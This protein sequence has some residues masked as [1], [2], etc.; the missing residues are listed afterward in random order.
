[1]PCEPVPLIV[2]RTPFR[3]RYAFATF[4]SPF[5][6][7]QKARWCHWFGV[8]AVLPLRVLSLLP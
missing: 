5:S 1:M 3:K 4:P 6:S 7:E 8:T 2:C